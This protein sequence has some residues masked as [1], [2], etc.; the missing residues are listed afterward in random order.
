MKHTCIKP[1]CGTAYEDKD[2]DPY[3]C[4]S[5]NEARKSIAKQVDE[6]FK[7]RSRKQVKTS[8]DILK[9]GGRISMGGGFI[10]SPGARS[11]PKKDGI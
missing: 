3:Y 4:P 1:G 11:A 7:G 9:G 10:F 6:K 2:L 5:C 8:W